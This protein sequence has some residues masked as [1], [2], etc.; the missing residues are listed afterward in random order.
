V[1]PA[2]DACCAI[3]W[4]GHELT[5]VDGSEVSKEPPQQINH[6]GPDERKQSLQQKPTNKR[7][8]AAGVSRCNNRNLRC[9][10]CAE[11]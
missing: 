6:P 10:V 1:N 8:L 4:L 5:P 7:N 11:Q 2:T 9:P 3:R